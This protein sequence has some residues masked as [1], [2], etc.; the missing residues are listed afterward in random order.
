MLKLLKILLKSEQLAKTLFQK[1][2]Q[3]EKMQLIQFQIFKKYN[4]ILYECLDYII[5]LKIIGSS[6]PTAFSSYYYFGFPFLKLFL[7]LILHKVELMF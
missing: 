4:L 1:M 7:S 3:I 2:I 5:K 6:K